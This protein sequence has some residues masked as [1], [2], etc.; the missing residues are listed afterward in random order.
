MNW[1]RSEN[2]Q[3]KKIIKIDL[4]TGDFK[5]SKMSLDRLSSQ[6][7]LCCMATRQKLCFLSFYFAISLELKLIPQKN[8]DVKGLWT[9]QN[10]LRCQGSY[11]C[12]EVRKNCV[13]Q[14]HFYHFYGLLPGL[15]TGQSD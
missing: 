6:G 3:Y 5:N 13:L 9:E 10:D 7:R 8:Y 12:G 14:H 11:Y 4:I 15:W 2:H 1:S